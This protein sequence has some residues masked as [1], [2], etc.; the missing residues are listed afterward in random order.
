MRASGSGRAARPAPKRA[1]RVAPNVS[2]EENGDVR[3]GELTTLVA[4]VASAAAL[5]RAAAVAPSADAAD[6]VVRGR[7]VANEAELRRAWRDPL[8]RRIDLTAD[9]FLRDC[10]TGDPIRESPYPLLLRGHGHTIRQTCFEKRVLRQDGTG[11]LDLR[12][13][14]LTRG[15][16]DGPGAAVTTRGELTV[17]GGV[18]TQNLSEEPG[19]GLFSMRRVTVRRSQISGN[20]ANDDGGGVYARRGGVQVYDSVVS[21]NLVDGSGGA[22]GSTG[23][24]LVVRSQIDGNTTDGD[25][26]AL[27][28]DEDGDVTVIGSLIDGSDADGPGGA[29][30]TLDGDVAVLDSTLI[31]N[32]AD[33]RGGAV[34]GEADVLIVNST[35][36][37]NLAVAHAGGGIWARHDLVLL[38]AT[39]TDNYAEGEGGGA[40]AAGSLTVIG[41]TVSRNIASVAANLGSA[42]P[43]RAFGSIIG[44]AQVDEPTGDTRPTRR[45]CRVYRAESAGRNFL[46]DTSCE[47]DHPTDVFDAD[48]RLRP[49]EDDP[50]GFVL[51][52]FD[53]SPVRARIP[54]GACRPPL[55]R[56]LPA[57]QLLDAHVDWDEL[58]ARDARGT[59]RDGGTPC[60]VGAVQSPP[61]APPRAADTLPAARR[62]LAAR[63]AS[64]RPRAA[65]SAAARH[66]AASGGRRG[67]AAA[68][69]AA[70]RRPV[71]APRPRSL[72]RR[73]DA[74]SRR[75]TALDRASR[76]FDVML[77]CTS[78]LPVGQAG[79]ARHRWG[80]RYDERDG[81]GLDLRPALVAH[82][83][84][85]LADLRFLRLARTRRCLSA[86][87]DPNGTGKAA[88][89]RRARASAARERRPL[90]RLDALESLA[91]RVE[92]RTERFDAWESC[93][94]AVPVTEAGDREQGL[95]YLRADGRSQR[96]RHDAAIAVDS[97][98]RDDPDYQLAAFAGR[99]RPF[100]P[101]ECDTEPGEEGFRLPSPPSARAVV[102]ALSGSR[103]RRDR[104]DRL[105]R[106]AET[107]EDLGEP[108]GEITQF[109]E[110]MYTVG[111]RQRDGYVFERRGR[112]R[113]RPALS[114]DMRGHR[115][116]QYDLVALPG[117]EPPQIE[118][119]EDAAGQG[120]DE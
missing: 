77:A 4:A 53:G 91:A 60:D 23:D 115:P 50:K 83:G 1:V 114:F 35:V 100:G 118:C 30:F 9:V 19:G 72:D 49:L 34:S 26:G 75:L 106:L 80:F 96:E 38:N 48:P 76:R 81:T 46:T 61:L 24:I 7:E 43:L 15:G 44:P 6:G 109:D 111:V 17:V 69:G 2:R 78:E 92:R 58:L 64:G 54:S 90:P 82:R 116:A 113:R 70:A 71:T 27:Y 88:Q 52:P 45:S 37:R 99:D 108:V 31:G 40:L 10:A 104:L 11:Y 85:G 86:A 55:P 3:V 42:G 103:E 97:S 57:G 8:T 41:S 101:G 119:N 32:R 98:E 13:V 120:T 14:T 51:E 117:E 112:T 84:S 95:G 66:A 47:L 89:A 67:R 94:S 107:V 87:P 56:R 68:G 16:S 20:L 39:V 65:A 105:D 12:D 22:I 5:A 93:L 21:N 18:V 73:L 62:A 59:V 102:A 29:I 79:D 25:G 33:D 36:A 74:L 28:A 110:C 63:S